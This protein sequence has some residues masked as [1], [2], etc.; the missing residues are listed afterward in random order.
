MTSFLLLAAL[1]VGAAP[2]AQHSGPADAEQTINALFDHI[3]GLEDRQKGRDVRTLR[4]LDRQIEALKPEVL[5]FGAQALGPLSKIAENP[6]RREKTRLWALSFLAL[7]RDPGALEPL[8]RILDD[9]KSPP[10][11]RADAAS[12]IP[13]L[14]V[15]AAARRRALCGA[16]ELEQ[17]AEA[18]REILFAL[19]RLGCAEPGALER[20]AR[21]AGSRP[22]GA[23]RVD[24]GRAVEALGRS[25]GEPAA[26]A[27]W[28]LFDFYPKG[29]PERGQVLD[30]LF[31]ARESLLAFA[32]DARRA[33]DEAL[34]AEAG[35]PV[36]AAAAARLLAFFD[37]PE[38]AP[39][40]LRFLDNQ[41]AEAVTLCAE[42]L[43]RLKA[44]EALK[45][46]AKIIEGLAR[47]PRFAPKAGRPDPGALARRLQDA[48]DRLS[49]AP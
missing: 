35:R 16:L 9:P 29:S 17:P 46:L 22:K 34:Q 31:N 18:R 13:S 5:K 33:A 48:F 32:G 14:E 10:L 3:D 49:A 8:E 24:A 6:A 11:L 2:N 42:G 21:E 37:A 39:T 12:A 36:N 45:P 47:D 43:A 44:K 15:G 4:E 27:L 38:A 28:R 1:S 7:T 40:L 23:S 25:S 19:S 20:R 41:D 30:A 26:R